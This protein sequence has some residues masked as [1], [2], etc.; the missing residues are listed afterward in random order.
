MSALQAAFLS[1]MASSQ[2]HPRALGPPNQTW[3]PRNHAV[4]D[5]V[6]AISRCL[7]TQNSLVSTD[8]NPHHRKV[9]LGA[10]LTLGSWC[11]FASYVHMVT[12]Q[13]VFGGGASD[14]T[15]SQNKTLKVYIYIHIRDELEFVPNSLD[16][17]LYISMAFSS[18]NSG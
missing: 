13:M 2:T 17:L 15:K 8:D 16:K 9:A 14:R 12:R 11:P 1:Q 10:G 18:L 5:G 3:L 6:Q 4:F 7:G